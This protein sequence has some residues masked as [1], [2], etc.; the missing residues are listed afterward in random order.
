MKIAVYALADKE[1]GMGH[2]V[3]MSHLI[4]LFK[5]RG[6]HVDVVTDDKGHR[7]FT[8]QGQNAIDV[9]GANTIVNADIAIVDHMMTDNQYLHA[10]RPGA[11]KLVV[12]VG[13]GHTIT[14]ETRW[15]ADLIVYQ[16]PP[17][18]ELYGIVPG[19]SIIS[20]YSHIMLDPIYATPMNE[21]DRG[22]DFVAYFG[23]G[24][25]LAFVSKIV[26]HLRDRDF[27]VNWVGNA[28]EIWTPGL[29]EALSL[30]TSFVGTMGMVTYEA[31][32]TKTKPIVFSRSEDHLEIAEQLADDTQL[33]NLG[34]LPQRA[35]NVDK[36]VNKIIKAHFTGYDPVPSVDG[37]GVYRVARE[38]LK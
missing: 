36:Y 10:I 33:E 25:K 16:C 2:V 29:Y 37:K 24:T 20:G 38:I 15:I 22:N 5:A 21:L 12:V 1:I 8:S 9:K 31:L 4:S 27:T 17:R 23:G 35:V 3:R 7:Y 14:P 30:A 32:A 6:H 11:K 26:G 19:E 13:A 34:L 28:S 18:E